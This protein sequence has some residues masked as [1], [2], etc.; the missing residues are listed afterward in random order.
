MLSILRVFRKKVL[1]KRNFGKYLFYAFGELILVV[2]G[3]LIALQINLW[4]TQ[5]SNKN[6]ERYTLNRFSTDLISDI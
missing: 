4:N 2:L 6:Q 5:K 1:V 3:I